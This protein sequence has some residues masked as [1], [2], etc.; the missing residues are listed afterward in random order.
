MVSTVLPIWHGNLHGKN[1]LSLRN[2]NFVYHIYTHNAL[3]HHHQHA[4]LSSC[5]YPTSSPFAMCC[6]RISIVW[7]F[8]FIMIKRVIVFIN[9]FMKERRRVIII[10]H[11]DKGY[12]IYNSVCESMNAAMYIAYA[13]CIV[14]MR[15]PGWPVYI[16]GA[17]HHARVFWVWSEEEGR[18]A[19][20]PQM[21]VNH[22]I[23]Q[24]QHPKKA[25]RLLK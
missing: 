23:Q 24:Q 21:L 14:L 13:S 7:H 3:N 11:N 5:I 18:G 9:L 22:A 19:I 17:G 20:V 2:N 25:W 8:V 16:K 4:A 1:P 15:V 10:P 6:C 12:T